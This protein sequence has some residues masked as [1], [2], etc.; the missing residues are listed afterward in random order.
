M[1]EQRAPPLIIDAKGRAHQINLDVELHRA[2]LDRMRKGRDLKIIITAKNSQT[3][4]GKTTLAGW[5][6]L[7]WTRW[8]GGIPW[9]CN[10]DKPEDGMATLNP[11]EYFKIVK[12]VGNEFPAGTVVLVDDAEELDARRSMQ[13][14]N[15]EFSQRWMLMR[16]K[17]AITIITLPSPSSIDSRLEELADYWI[18]IERRGRALVHNIEVQDYGARNVLTRQSHWVTYPDVSDHPEMQKLTEMKQDKMDDWDT[19]TEDGPTP[20]EVEKET[21][22]EHAQRLRDMGVPIEAQDPETPDIVSTIDMSQ[23]WISKNTQA[24]G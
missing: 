23:S 21:K 8:L 7:S 5:L 14:L 12:K 10:P 18:N 4:V 24:S 1:T 15:V 2:A 6:A 3:G 17:Q 19:Q 20:A 13:S 9:Y 22:R 16:L 11:G